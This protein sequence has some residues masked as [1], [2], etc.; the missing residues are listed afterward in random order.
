[1]RQKRQLVTFDGGRRVGRVIDIFRRCDNRPPNAD[2]VDL[3]IYATVECGDFM[4]QSIDGT[5]QLSRQQ[6]VSVQLH[7]PLTDLKTLPDLVRINDFP[8]GSFNSF[9]CHFEAATLQSQLRRRAPEL[10]MVS[11]A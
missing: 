2:P 8:E 3:P 9:L 1:M 5:L 10:W 6:S 11:F 4:L 7:L